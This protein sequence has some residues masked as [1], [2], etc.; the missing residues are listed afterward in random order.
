MADSTPIDASASLPDGTALDG[1][2]SLRRLVA[3]HPEDFARTFTQ[4]LLGFA[5]GRGIEPADQS[6]VRHITRDAAAGGYRWSSLIQ[7]IVASPP[8]RMSTAQKAPIPAP[9]STAAAR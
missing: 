8:F 5:L 2:A 1:V 7:G 9:G 4:K 3:E 6:A